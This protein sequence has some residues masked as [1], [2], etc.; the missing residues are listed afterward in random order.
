MC[1]MT[2][3]SV[4]SVAQAAEY[5]YTFVDTG[6]IKYFNSSRHGSQGDAVHIYN[7]ALAPSPT[8]S[9]VTRTSTVQTSW[10]GNEASRLIC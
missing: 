9:M 3:L 5:S 8:I 1:G 7:F 2:L 4:F 10:L 6:Q